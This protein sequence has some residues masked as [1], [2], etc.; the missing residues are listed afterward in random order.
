MDR[1]CNQWGVAADN[2]GILV[3]ASDIVC[4]FVDK[5]LP[6]VVNT[7]YIPR[8]EVAVDSSTA[9]ADRHRVGVD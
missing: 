6:V 5:A 9:V 1:G 7:D 2:P 3:F 4:S 8:A